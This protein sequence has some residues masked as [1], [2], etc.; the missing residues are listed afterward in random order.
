MTTEHPRYAIIHV[1][2]DHGEAWPI[3]ERTIGGWQSGV[4]H[5]PDAE[6]LDVRPLVLVALDGESCNS[7]DA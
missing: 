6:V 4:H 3:V 7:A 1:R 5:Y 2:S